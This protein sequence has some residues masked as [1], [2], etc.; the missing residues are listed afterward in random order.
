MRMT[1]QFGSITSIIPH[2]APAV[3]QSSASS[4]PEHPQTLGELIPQTNG[5][6]QGGPQSMGT[7]S[8]QLF[9]AVV[10][11]QLNSKRSQSSSW[12]WGTHKSGISSDWSGCP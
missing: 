9:S 4:V 12:V 11:P 8:P 10:S 1:P 5:A 2:S 6:T 7:V 3:A